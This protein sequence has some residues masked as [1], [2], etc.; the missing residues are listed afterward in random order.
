[1]IRQPIS[2]QAHIAL[3]VVSVVVLLLG[4][5]WLSHR[6]HQKNP[7]DTTIPNWTQLAHGVTRIL[8][9]QDRYD[10]ASWL[11]TDAKATFT[12]HFTGLAV[13]V[14]ASIVIGLA[15]GCFSPIEALLLPPL[16]WLAK[17]PPTAMLAVFFV[18]VGT[19]MELYVA[20]IA[21]GVIPTLSQSIYQSVRTDVPEELIYKAYTLGASHAELIW[22]VTFKQILPRIIEAVRLQVGP[23]MV[24]LI[25]AEYAIGDAGFGF[26]LRMQQRLSDMSTVYLYLVVLAAVGFAM[27]Y[28]LTWLRRL[29]CPW[30]GKN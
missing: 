5:T 14:A 18:L 19:G 2:R 7:T 21:F 9:P 20:M 15:M 13:G 4:Y 8:K 27:D 30:F 11:W 29:I 6:Q 17:I 26:R 23:A 16:S 10:G 3:G 25:A 22:N 28:S 24:Y 1:M 12:R